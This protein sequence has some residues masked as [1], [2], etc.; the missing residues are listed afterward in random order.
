MPAK[1]ICFICDQPPCHLKIPTTDKDGSDDHQSCLK[2]CD[3][4]TADQRHATK[5]TRIHISPITNR[6]APK[7]KLE[8]SPNQPVGSKSAGGETAARAGEGGEG[9][10]TDYRL[11]STIPRLACSIPRRMGCCGFGRRTNRRRPKPN[12]EENGEAKRNCSPGFPL[13]PQSPIAP[14]GRLAAPSPPVPWGERRR[15]R[16]SAPTFASSSSDLSPS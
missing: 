10:G 13:P 16:A 2:A 6:T 11:R 1:Q 8:R 9:A 4:L 15:T 7:Q 14:A 12:R 3:F 5:T